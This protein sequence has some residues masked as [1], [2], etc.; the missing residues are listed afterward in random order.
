MGD[1]RLLGAGCHAEW[2]EEAVHKDVELLDILSLSLQHTEHNLVPLPHALSMWGADV[3]LDNGL[4]LPSA[5]PSSQE[6]LDL[7]DTAMAL[8]WRVGATVKNLQVKP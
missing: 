7:L 4:P 3:V 2:S 1:R 8:T 5:Q 6:A